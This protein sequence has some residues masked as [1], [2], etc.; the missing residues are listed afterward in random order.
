MGLY[1]KPVPVSFFPGNSLPPR[2]SP[3]SLSPGHVH[4][5]G[6]GRGGGHV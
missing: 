1:K 2:T 4:T 5:R 6:G 3:V